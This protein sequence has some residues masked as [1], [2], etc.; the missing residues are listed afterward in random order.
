VLEA[1]GPLDHAR[2]TALLSQVALGLDKVHEEGVVHRDLKPSNLFVT[3]RDDG[4]PCVKILDF[5]VAKVVCDLATLRTTRSLGTPL[6]M[7]PEQL[8]GDATI[9]GTADLYALAH[10]AFTM[11]AGKPYWFDEARSASNA[12]AFIHKVA[13]GIREGASVRAE[14]W[15]VTLPPS[16]D[17]WFE[18]AAAHDPTQRFATAREQVDALARAL[19][20]EQPPVPVAAPPSRRR[21]WVAPGAVLALGVLALVMLSSV[22]DE[23]ATSPAPVTTTPP[24]PSTSP[25]DERGAPATS[26]DA[27]ASAP[28]A[29]APA[30]SAAP[31]PTRSGGQ[32]RSPSPIPPA[33]PSDS[34]YD[35]LDEL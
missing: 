26:A 20:E 11:L 28:I 14:R 33:P 13:D 17:A 23:P 12:Y 25:V 16:F 3:E 7:A 5:G 21:N 27:S 2:T 31:P 24:A 15:D 10:V 1:E 4:S 30:P 32:V 29:S 9:D 18:K 6:Y 19:D 22:D 8:T 34:T 35:P